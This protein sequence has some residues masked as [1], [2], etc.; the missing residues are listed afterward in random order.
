MF[1]IIIVLA[2]VILPAVLIWL[3]W[4]KSNFS[5]RKKWLA[6]ALIALAF[7]LLLNYSDGSP[8]GKTEYA[9][10]ARV[11]D[12]DT[13]QL[14]DGRR[15]R[16][17]GIE[18]PEIVHPDKPVECFGK[19]ANEEN[20][21]LVEGK[22]VRLEKDVSETDRYD[23]ILRYVYIDDTFVNEH[24]IRG[25]FAFVSIFPPDVKYQDQLREAMA[26]AK[27]NNRGLWANGV[28]N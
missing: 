15:V 5:R 9:K 14:E 20:R 7:L 19:E 22:E 2:F 3:V 11:I 12:G 16:Y 18:T 24:L 25:G 26:D 8:Q 6:T 23:R 13:V 27:E 21:M 1:Y 4:K 10:V 28:C 17:I